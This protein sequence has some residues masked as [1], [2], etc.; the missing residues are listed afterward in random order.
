MPRRV[1]VTLPDPVAA[2]LQ[3]WADIRGQAL[4]TVAALAIEKAMDE[5]KAQGEITGG[6]G[7]KN[8]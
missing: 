5:L 2:N 3:E 8:G 4:A 1:T 6:K 7:A